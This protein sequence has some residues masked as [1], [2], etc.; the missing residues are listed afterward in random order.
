MSIKSINLIQKYPHFTKSY[1][2][3]LKIFVT[4][5]DLLEILLE[6]ALHQTSQNKYHYY[7]MNTKQ[8]NVFKYWSTHQD[9]LHML[10]HLFYQA[11]Y[12]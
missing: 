12:L 3:I 7:S 1:P 6:Y 10:H 8:S 2:C 5:V 9:L 11:D 4:T